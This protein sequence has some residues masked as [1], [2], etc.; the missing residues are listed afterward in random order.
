MVDA[1]NAVTNGGLRSVL[2]TA[3][4]SGLPTSFSPITRTVNYVAS[5][6][7]SGV[8]AVQSVTKRASGTMLS[9][10][11]ASVTAYNVVNLHRAYADGNVALKQD[12]KALVNE[13]G[14]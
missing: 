11:R 5:G 7:A 1:V 6:V 4:V 13:I 9:P 2:Y 12:E 10:A 14:N 8:T 3:D